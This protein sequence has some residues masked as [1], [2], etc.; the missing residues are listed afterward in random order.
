MKETQWFGCADPESTL[1]FLKGKASE[2]KLRPF[3]VACCR[4]I[5]HLL[6]SDAHR[7]AVEK[8]EKIADNSSTNSGF[9]DDDFS[10]AEWDRAAGHNDYVY[11][12]AHEAVEQAVLHGDAWE[13]A[14][15]ASSQAA[16]AVTAL[17]MGT[18]AWLARKRAE[19]K[20]QCELLLDIFG[21]PASTAS[22]NPAWLTW[23]DGAL[24]KMAQPIYD[25]RDFGRLPILADAL[26]DAGCAD[27]AILAHCRTPGEHVRGC[28][29]IDLLL[30][31]S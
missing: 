12:Y 15:G 9:D 3:A 19:H 2:R 16:A 21:K 8:A 10:F 13:A 22:P 30:G 24:R 23:N 4:Y 20:A 6:P 14:S 25:E 26:E 17:S 5:W 1:E 29:V 28:W 11:A 27:A 31:K 18:S 7:S